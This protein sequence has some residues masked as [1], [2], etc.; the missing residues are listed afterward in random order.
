MAYAAGY[1][2]EWYHIPDKKV[3]FRTFYLCGRKWGTERCHTLTV[4]SL[5][6]RLHQDPIASGQR[7][8]CPVCEARYKPAN[9]VMVEMLIQGVSYYIKAPFPTD[10]IIDL[11]AMAVETYHAGAQSPEELLKAIPEAHP[12]GAEWLVATRYEGTYSYQEAVF[13][14]I[15]SLDWN[16]IYNAV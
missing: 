10:D 7:W 13:E 9:G 4:S 8:Y 3:S 2:D 5:W 11:K 6:N 1:T 14:D 16:Q 15:P 12:L